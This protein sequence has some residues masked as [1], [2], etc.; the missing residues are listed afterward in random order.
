MR[1]TSVEAYHKVQ[2]SGLLADRQREAYRTFYSHGPLTGQELN[3]LMT[4]DGAW[5]LC[6]PL[7][8]LGLIHEVGKTKCKVTG[9]TAY[10][11]DV[12]SKLPPE[13][14]PVRVSSAEVI[15][16]LREDINQYRILME[17]INE[18]LQA[19][20]PLETGSELHQSIQFLLKNGANGGT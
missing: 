5:K 11:W 7:K 17:Q 12:T 1:S 2:E 3:S 9:N 15:S 6:A 16:N 8:G 19:N 18:V 14:K 4:G 13:E 10:L 20:I